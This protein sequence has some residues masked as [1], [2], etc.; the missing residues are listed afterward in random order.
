MGESESMRLNCRFR[1]LTRSQD[2]VEESTI[3]VPLPS[4]QQP[5]QTVLTSINVSLFDS[6]IVSREEPTISSGSSPASPRIRLMQRPKESPQARVERASETVK[7]PARS[8][9]LWNDDEWDSNKARD[10]SNRKLW[11]D[12]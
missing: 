12:A 8:G 7:F 4:V 9:D 11:E 1:E 6:Q 2:D 5:P 10:L 3:Q